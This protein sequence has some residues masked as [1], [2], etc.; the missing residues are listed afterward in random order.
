MHCY[1]SILMTIIVLDDGGYVRMN[2]LFLPTFC[3]NTKGVTFGFLAQNDYARFPRK[4]YERLSVTPLFPEI[5]KGVVLGFLVHNDHDIFPQK[6]TWTIYNV[7]ENVCTKK[8]WKKNPSR[9]PN[10]WPFAK[11]NECTSC[12]LSKLGQIMLYR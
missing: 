2:S 3:R 10:Y 4:S 1:V 7:N 6:F 11:P 12:N 8:K 9:A 5:L